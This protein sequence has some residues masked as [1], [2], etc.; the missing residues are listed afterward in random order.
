MFLAITGKNKG[1][2]HQKNAPVQYCTGVTTQKRCSRFRLLLQVQACISSTVQT[3]AVILDHIDRDFV[4][5]RADVRI[6][7]LFEPGHEQVVAFE[8]AKVFL[9]G[10]TSKVETAEREEERCGIACETGKHLYEQ[11]HHFGGYRVGVAG[12]ADV[13]RAV[14]PIGFFNFL[15]GF[16]IGNALRVAPPFIEVGKAHAGDERFDAR[17]GADPLIHVIAE[18][19]GILVERGERGV[20]AFGASRD[21]LLSVECEE[22]NAHAGTGANHGLGRRLRSGG[23][24]VGVHELENLFRVIDV[25]RRDAVA[26]GHKVVDDKRRNAGCVRD[27]VAIDAPR[28]VRHDALVVRDRAC[29]ADADVRGLERSV[30]FGCDLERFADRCIEPFNAL[31]RANGFENERKF[32]I[33]VAYKTEVRVRTTDITRQDETVKLCIGIKPFN[34]H[35]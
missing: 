31:A 22:S 11:T 33:L 5:K 4:Q 29:G 18:I 24:S 21:V 28:E 30:A 17:H 8:P 35:N 27:G 10:T 6:V 25:E 32:A 1:T 20:A 26:D 7:V 19:L 12:A 13:L 2:I 9:Y 23:A 14:M 15:E 16:V 3:N 34:F